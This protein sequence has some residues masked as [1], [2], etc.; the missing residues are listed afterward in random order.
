MK[1]TVEAEILARR[2]RTAEEILDAFIDIRLKYYDLRKTHILTTLKSDIEKLLSKYLFV[3]G[4]ID[5]TIVVAN[6]KKEDIIKQLEKVDKIIKV[7][8]T[9]EYLLALPIHSLTKERLEE[10]KKQIEESK[11]EFKRVK[12]TTIQEMWTADL[13]ELKK[14]L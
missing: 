12:G 13:H 10:L 3:K 9:Y 6:K 8:G 14:V 7:N 1:R 11:A 5:K 4:I 2:K